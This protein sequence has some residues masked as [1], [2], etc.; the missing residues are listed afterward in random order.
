MAFWPALALLTALSATPRYADGARI[1]LCTV[2]GARASGGGA[3]LVAPAEWPL[4]GMYG[5]TRYQSNYGRCWWQIEWPTAWRVAG[6]RTFHRGVISSLG[7]QVKVAAEPL[8]AAGWAQAPVVARFAGPLTRCNDHASQGYSEVTCAPVEARCLRL[9]FLGHNGAEAGQPG[10][11]H[12]DLVVGKI[13]LWGPNDPVTSPAVS[14]A[15]SPWAGAS[16]VYTDPLGNGGDCPAL[17]DDMD[18]RGG[19]FGNCH[20]AFS[21]PGS[22]PNPPARGGPK[23]AQFTVTLA[24]RAQV[25]AVGYA[26]LVRQRDDRP[27]DLRVYVSPHDIGPRWTLAKE[28]RDIAG[29]EYEEIAFDQPLLAKRVRF[30][31]VRVWNPREDARRLALGHLAELFVYGT[32]LPPDLVVDLAQQALTSASV[33]DG[34]G[35]SVRTLWQLQRYPQGPRELY[36]DGLDDQFGVVPAGDYRLRVVANAGAYRNVAAIGN[37]GTPPNADTHTPTGIQSLCVDRDGCIWSANGWDEAGHDWHRWSPDGATHLDARYQIRNGTPNGLPYRVA[38]DEQ[39]LY[40]AY[41]SHNDGGKA[42]SQWLQRFDRRTGKAAPWPQG[43]D[44]HGLI[45]VYPLPEQK[46]WDQPI[47]GLAVTRDALLVGDKRAGRILVY[48]KATGGKRREQPCDQPGVLATDAR[49]RIWAVQGGDKVVTFGPDLAAPTVALADQGQ[50][51]GLSFGADGDLLVADAKAGQVRRYGV[52]GP[53][54]VLRETFGS[55]AAPGDA[56][57]E[58]FYRLVDVAAT[59]DGGFVTAQRMPLGGCRLS[60][61]TARRALAWEHLGLEFTGNGAYPAD[62][63]DLFT[64]TYFH[65]YRLDRAKDGW[66]FD[67]NQYTGGHT[68]DWHGAPRWIK[69]GG[70]DFFCF[71]VGDGLV[72]YRREGPALRFCAALGGGWP[73]VKGQRG[74]GGKLGQWTWADANNDGLVDDA[75]VNWYKPPGQGKYAVYGMNIDPQGN[76]IYCDHHPRAIRMLPVRGLNAAGNPLWDWAAAQDLVPRDESPVKFFPL[77]AVR[78]ETGSLYAFGRSDLYPPDPGS[79]PAWMSG[80]VLARYAA[81][82]RRE[83]VRRL[84]NHCTGMD[85]VPG[86][87]G[88][89]CGYFATATLYHYRADGTLVGQMQPGEAAGNLSGWLDNTAS[90]AVNVD[91]RDGRIDVFAEEDYAH[92]ILWYRADDSQISVRDYP[93]RWPG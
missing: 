76:V 13:Q 34:Q 55:A 90:V 7:Y 59:P 33:V 36:F 83:W 23:P 6:V 64:S 30:E 93:L 2:R 56:Q 19:G 52:G 32:A 61:W 75:E 17:V 70:R 12:G 66:R 47:S 14:L 50:V 37:T 60:C 89:V 25:E 85:Y 3:R 26:A 48:D 10:K 28:L 72:A 31:I 74:E 67:G 21:A 65:R 44:K 91:P 5:E 58:R 29:G 20:F 79:G 4:H 39:W 57:A 42:G 92:R 73:D 22:A 63:P 82:G 86:E 46:S 9:E 51:V 62:N 80:W 8:D 24:R 78:T 69:L 88:V 45:Q 18:P 15:S 11:S 27:R 68:G 84:P 77:M 40:V 1:N 71:A 38:V 54:P 49:E 53:T 87:R 41:I 35:R 43:F 16:C 81:D